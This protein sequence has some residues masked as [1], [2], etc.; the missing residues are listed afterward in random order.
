M[1]RILLL[2][3]GLAFAA[4]AFPPSKAFAQTQT[5]ALAAEFYPLLVRGRLVGCQIAFSTVRLDHEFNGGAPTVVRGLLL[6]QGL[7]GERPGAMLRL[8]VRAFDEPDFVP[9]DRAYLM[10]G[11]QTNV[12]DAGDSFLSDSVG[13]RA[14]PFALGQS[15]AE[16]IGQFTV[17]GTLRFSYGLPNTSVD[18]TAGVDFSEQ[19]RAFADWAT[20]VQHV[21]QQ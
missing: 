11:M 5:S 20:C 1:R 21:V 18:A 3:A 13:F 17:E 2:A 6:F 14:F 12:A 7:D 8:G 16:A 10:T 9:P 4:C 19:P 15:T